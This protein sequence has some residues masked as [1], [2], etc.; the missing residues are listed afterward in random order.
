[1]NRKSVSG[2]NVSILL[3][4][5][6][7]AVVVTAACCAI[8][9]LLI[10]KELMG[11]SAADYCVPMTVMLSSFAG[12]KL[13]LGRIRER[14]MVIG[15]LVA[16]VYILMLLAMTALFFGGQYCGIGVTAAAALGGGAVAAILGNRGEK[17][18]VSR[19]SKLK[20]R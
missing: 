2:K 11:E 1:M 19:K 4:G 14:R 5:G 9:A 7:T 20:H 15:A 3:W 18:S 17:R 13:A 6:L 16:M 8:C 12:G 10:G